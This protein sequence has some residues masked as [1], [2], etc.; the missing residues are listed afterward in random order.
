MGEPALNL[1]LTLREGCCHHPDLEQEI[2]A[3]KG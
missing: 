1:H 2:K 3:Q